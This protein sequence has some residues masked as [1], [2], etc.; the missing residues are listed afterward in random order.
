MSATVL[1]ADSGVEIGNHW[2]V[3]VA[4]YSLNMDTIVGTLLSGAIVIGLGL[5]V[6]RGAN[7][8]NPTRLQIFFETIKEAIEDQVEENLGIKTAP[9]VVPFAFAIAMLILFS[10]LLA[11]LPTEAILPPPTADVN[12]TFALALVVMF[13]V[14]WTAIKRQPGRFFGHFKNPMAIVE[15]ITKPISLSLR[16]FGNVLSGTIMIQ[17]I[18]AL[19]VYILWAPFTI[20]KLFDIFIAVLQAVIFTILT[21]IYLGQ[22]IGEDA[23]AH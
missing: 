21:I 6:A 15:E 12:L 16:L 2:T 18:V 10:N 23:D 5:W 17:L 19:P 7:A 8:G 20:W 3:E 4:G 9:W 14:W 11:I 13:V 1:A 22:A